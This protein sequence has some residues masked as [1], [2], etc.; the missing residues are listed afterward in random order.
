MTFAPPF[1]L[2][3]RVG[4]G[5]LLDALTLEEVDTDLFRATFVAPDV[6]ALY[7]GQVAAQA[8]LAAGRTVPEGVLPHSLHGYFLRAGDSEHPTLLRVRRD[9]DG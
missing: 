5:D 2:A 8:L 7:G 4:R 6:M 9:R 3:D 1:T